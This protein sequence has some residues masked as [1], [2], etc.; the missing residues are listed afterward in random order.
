MTSERMRN[1]GEVLRDEMVMQDKILALLADGPLT[2]PE[3][4]EALKMPSWEITTWVMAMRR[5]GHL[6]E[7]PKERAEDYFQYAMVASEPGEEAS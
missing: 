7:M 3:I 1:L 2:I 6:K 4:V 5:Y